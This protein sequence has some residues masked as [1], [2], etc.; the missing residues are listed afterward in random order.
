M[1]KLIYKKMDNKIELN[2]NDMMLLADNSTKISVFNQDQNFIH[3]LSQIYAN[4]FIN[5]TNYNFI[6]LKDN[7]VIGVCLGIIGNDTKN[8]KCNLDDV[9]TSNQAEQEFIIFRKRI[10]QGYKDLNVSNK[11]ELELF[12]S[13]IKNQGIGSNLLKLFEQD[14]KQQGI[15]EY[16]LYTNE[17]CDYHYYLKNNYTLIGQIAID[18]SDLDT[19]FGNQEKFMIMCFKKDI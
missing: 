7:H 9:K 14:L 4:Y 5:K 18:I 2:L 19:I 17:M 1:E 8:V 15:N 10:T 16:Y 11:V 12:S 6:C 3:N 13:L